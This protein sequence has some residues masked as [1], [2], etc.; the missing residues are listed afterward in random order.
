MREATWQGRLGPGLSLREVR[1]S[2]LAGRMLL[3]SSLTL[4]EVGPRQ[5]HSP[6]I[7]K[8]KTGA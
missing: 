3:S 1:G 5:G 4:K 6:E 2:S 7:S 8:E